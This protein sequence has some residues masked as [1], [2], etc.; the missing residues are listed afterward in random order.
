MPHYGYEFDY[1]YPGMEMGGMTAVGAVFAFIFLFYLV[2]MGWGIASYIFQ[3]LGLYTIAKRRGIY[4][5][6]LSWLPFGSMWILGS[7]SDQY[8]HVAKGCVKNRR[9]ILLG[10]TIAMVA[11]MLLMY[12]GMFGMALGVVGEMEA[13]AATGGVVT[14]LA[15]VGFLVITVI[16][17]VY[18][19]IATY[20]LYASCEPNNA[21]LY[22]VLSIL[23]SV[24]MPVFIFVCRKKDLGMPPRKQPEPEI[25]VFQPTE[26]SCE[27]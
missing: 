4:N 7:I 20:D 3:S 21:V 2:M 22:L 10:L 1:I 15:A 19:Y 27:E 18:Q 8:Q 5:P 17:V 9:K 13:V 26:Q 24:V 11:V 23:F 25:P 12:A 6:W 16:A 14:V